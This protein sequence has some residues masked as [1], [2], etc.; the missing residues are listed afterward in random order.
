MGTFTATEFEIPKYED[1]WMDNGLETF[2][3]TL[4]SASFEENAFSTSLTDGGLILQL[5]DPELFVKQLT[6][7]INER[8]KNLILLTE[9]RKTHLKKEV[10]KDFVIIQEEKKVNGKV[11]LKEK[12]FKPDH[13]EELVREIIENSL[14]HSSRKAKTCILCGR[15]YGKTVKKLQ[16]ANYPLA[17]KIRSLSGVRSD[18]EGKLSLKDYYD[19]LCPLC[20]LVGI[21]EWTDE[22]TI[23]RILPKKEAYLFLP[24][25][26]SLVA[27]NRFKKYCIYVLNPLGRYSDIRMNLSTDETENT[28]GKF[29]TLLC[30][31]EKLV[32]TSDSPLLA[33]QWSVLTIPVGSNMKNVKTDE[34]NVNSGILGVIK[35]LKESETLERLYSDLVKKV[36]FRSEAK[37]SIDNAETGVVQENMAKYFL[38]DDFRRFTTSLLPRKGGFVLF[39]A[40]TR[41]NL[42]ELIYEW[43]WKRMGLQKEKL[44]TIK[45]M[46]NILAK[47]SSA[48]IS[49]LYKMDKVRDIG[50]F[51]SVLREISR[52]LLNLDESVLRKIRPTAID[53][54][55]T[56]TKTIEETDSDGWKEVR[57][58]II[59]YASM[60]Y[61]LD[62]LSKISQ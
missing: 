20:Y 48:N 22:A 27:L 2:Y 18:K 30:F 44:E 29:S 53:D 26:E 62:R 61:S 10:K 42:E 17:T 8:R 5:K 38:T 35:N 40:E 7:L 31:Y 36:Y 25:F 58:L 9:D 14:P 11:S 46:G 13:T 50:E 45:S 24:R 1:P 15:E 4:Q 3:R 51:W 43:R 41:Q 19:N 52:K 49:L 55:I 59:I 56:L 6:F 12:I 32:E 37:G 39:S 21:L 47:I 34:I 33:H 16:Q 60:Y 54:V 57:D 23:Y 28:P